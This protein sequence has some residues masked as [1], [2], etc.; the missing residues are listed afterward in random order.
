MRRSLAGGLVGTIALAGFA[1]GTGVFPSLRFIPNLENVPGTTVECQV[2]HAGS[3]GGSL[4]AFGE[5]VRAHLNAS[6]QPDW[7]A[8]RNLDSDG[9]GYTNG[10]E[11]GD[12]TGSWTPGSPDP[13]SPSAVTHPGSPTSKPSFPSSVQGVHITTTWAVIKALFR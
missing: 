11:L 8:I 6:R 13:S 2:C 3:Q 7:S 12:P 10:Q 9:D 5:T 4:N 1:L